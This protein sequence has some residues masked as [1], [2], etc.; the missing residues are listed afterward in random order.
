MIGKAM[1]SLAAI[2]SSIVMPALLL[3]A[4]PASAQ[5]SRVQPLDCRALA[6]SHRGDI[7]QTTFWGWK[8]DDFGFRRE[9]FASPCFTSEKDCKA[10]LY[11]ARSDY[12]PNYAPPKLCHR[13][14]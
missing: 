7:W 13:T 1:A 3:A 4:T 5:P 10:W 2:V 6:G 11:W 9:F 14:R 8:E 12:D